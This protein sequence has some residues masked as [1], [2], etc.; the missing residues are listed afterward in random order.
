MKQNLYYLKFP[1]FLKAVAFSLLILL[2]IG[3]TAFAQVTIT[4]KVTDGTTNESIPGATVTVK[5]TATAV[6]T[7]VDGVYSIHA[8]NN[9]I[10]IF[11]FLGYTP[12]EVPVGTQTTINVKLQPAVGQLKD[13]V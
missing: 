10:L 2:M 11:K 8:G 12:Q 7:N 5:G 1:F 6:G 9:A 3:S 13:V 4:G